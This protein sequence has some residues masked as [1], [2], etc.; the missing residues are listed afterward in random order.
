MDE[1]EEWLQQAA[2]E[3]VGKEFAKEAC[4]ALSVLVSAAAGSTDPAVA[5]AYGAFVTTTR[6]AGRL[7]WAPQTSPEKVVESKTD[8][9]EE[10][11]DFFKAEDLDMLK[12]IGL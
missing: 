6:A 7:G 3:L 1:Q 11:L 8:A 5:R 2:T 4:E 10:E 9:E 12:R